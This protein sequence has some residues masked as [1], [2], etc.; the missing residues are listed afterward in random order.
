VLKTTLDLT[1][2]RVANSELTRGKQIK[3]AKTIAAS[4]GTLDGTYT[5]VAEKLN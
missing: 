1:I 3:V 2:S 4:G 5:I